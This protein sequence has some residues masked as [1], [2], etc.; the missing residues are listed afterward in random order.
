VS[1]NW[2]PLILR[3]DTW[4]TEGLADSESFAQMRDGNAASPHRYE[5]QISCESILFKL[6]HRILTHPVAWPANLASFTSK[7]GETRRS[8]NFC[9]EVDAKDRSSASAV[10][11][12]LRIPIQIY[13]SVSVSPAVPQHSDH[14]SARKLDQAAYH[15]Q[16]CSTASLF[17]MNS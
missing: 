1:K 12:A 5:R 13:G 10:Q 17:A 2:K 16:K 7:I 14:L 15:M 8:E 6:I 3:T 9:A 4:C 11:H